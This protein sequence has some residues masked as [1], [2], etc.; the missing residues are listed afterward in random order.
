MGS[1]QR[2]TGGQ[3]IPLSQVII[4]KDYSSSSAAGANDLAL[5]QLQ[6]PVILNDNTKPIDLATARP[7]AGVQVTFS[8]W[9]S[10]KPDGALSHGLQVATRQS[11]SSADCQKELFLEQEDLLCL[12]PAAEEDT[13]GLCSGD[14]GAPAVYEDK[15]V[16]IAAF[17]VSGCSSGQPDG[18]VDVTQH[19]EW[20]IENSP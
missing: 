8:G 19:L 11:L 9:G 14:A 5:L 1:I 10:A 13:A 2:L 4:H 3:L 7:A 17:F 16:G 15:L 18:Y 6:T 20:I 12:S